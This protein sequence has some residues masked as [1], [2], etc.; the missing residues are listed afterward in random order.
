M[1]QL[2]EKLRNLIVDELFQK[3]VTNDEAA[4]SNE[5]YMNVDQIKC[6]NENGMHIGSHG[7]NHLW[8]DSLS[9]DQQEEE[10]ELSLN[11]LTKINA[12]VDNWV[13]CYPYGAYNKETITLIKN[14]G[15]VLGIT[16]EVRVANLT[17]D[18]PFKLPR[19]D[20]NDFPQ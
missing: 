15:A 20:T 5:L 2:V 1:L 8:L 13:M 14:F 9:A 4:F 6:L 10:I 19:L 7:Y 3:Y 16:T 18:D 17:S 11:F 12:P